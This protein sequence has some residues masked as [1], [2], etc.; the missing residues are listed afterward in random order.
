MV[1]KLFFKSV[2]SMFLQKIVYQ[3]IY[4]IGSYNTMMIDGQVFQISISNSL[5]LIEN[6]IRS[7]RK[8]SMEMQLHI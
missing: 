1:I 8:K 7:I 3:S 4:T 2:G 5:Q 6:W